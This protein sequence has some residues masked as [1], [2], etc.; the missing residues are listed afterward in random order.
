VTG[1]AFVLDAEGRPRFLMH[2]YRA[3]FGLGQ[4]PRARSS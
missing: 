2:T 3:L 1:E 4:Q